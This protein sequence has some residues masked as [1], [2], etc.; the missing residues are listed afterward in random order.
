MADKVETSRRLDAPSSKTVLGLNRD[1]GIQYVTLVAVAALV[2]SPLLPIAYQSVIDRP[3]YSLSGAFTFSN[4]VDLFT[5]FPFTRVILDTLLFA[6][7]TTIGAVLFGVVLAVLIVRT[8][9]PIRRV[10]GAVVL[11]PLYLSPLVVG[12]GW[13]LAYGPSGWFTVFFRTAVGAVPWNLYSIPGMAATA[14]VIYTP[15]AYLYCSGALKLADPSMESAARIS[16]AGPLRILRSVTLPLL[17]PPV[18]YSALLIFTSAIEL[19]SIPLLYGTPVGIDLFASFLYV[20]GLGTANPDYGILGAAAMILLLFMVVLVALQARLLRNARRFVSVGGKATRH[21]PLD[22]G[23]LRWLGLS[24]TLLFVLFGPIIPIFVLLLRAFTQILTPLVSPWTVLTLNN[25]QLIFTY[26]AYVNAIVNTVVIALIGG[27]ATTIFAGLAVMVARR[28]A[29]RYR[30]SVETLA[31]IPQ[32]VPGI[33][34]GL[35]FFWV[36]AVVGPASLLLGTIGALIIAFA[37]RT[38]PVAFG[39][40]APQTLQVDQELDQATR[41]MGADWWKVVSRFLPRLLLSSLLVSFT[42]VYVQ[43]TKELSSAIFLV[44]ADTRII[45]TTSLSL[46]QNGN[47]GAVAALS[48]VQVVITAVLVFAVSKIFKVRVY[49]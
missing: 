8:T 32:A 48:V 49:A 45:S 42:L 7:L 3:L 9:M 2:I 47:T 18:L 30:R 11:W 31:L 38:L 20:Y 41:A 35:G 33:V 43:M 25:M 5:E 23:P 12:F 34:V 26:P 40:I 29:F 13:I 1:S 22:L 39:S 36:F 27:V 46:W 4:Y 15:L 37:C 21:R 44:T 17:R 10:L 28:S 14:T 6:A 24:I 19:L 16:G